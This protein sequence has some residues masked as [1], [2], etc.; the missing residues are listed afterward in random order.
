M[1]HLVG[2]DIAMGIR[3]V[4]RQLL[5][6]ASDP[7]SQV[8][9]AR[10]PGIMMDVSSYRIEFISGLINYMSEEDQEVR[11]MAARAIEFLSTHPSNKEIV[12][13]YPGL[14]EKMVLFCSYLLVLRKCLLLMKMNMPGQ[15]Q[16]EP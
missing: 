16:D 2:D 5:N 3:Q 14:V 7:D 1:D 11:L 10:Q 15:F 9:M 8:L 6:L 12:A 13:T 4:V